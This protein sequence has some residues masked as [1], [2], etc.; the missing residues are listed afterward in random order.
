M[1]VFSF[2]VAAGFEPL[3][4]GGRRLNRYPILTPQRK[5]KERTYKVAIAFT[6]G[7]LCAA[8]L[9]KDFISKY[10]RESD[11]FLFSIPYKGVMSP[12]LY[13]KALK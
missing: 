1:S 10:P 8:M 9:L 7:N 6:A 4:L 2:L 13:P 5:F 11:D 12:I 3:S